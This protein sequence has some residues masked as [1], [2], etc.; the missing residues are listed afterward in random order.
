VEGVNFGGGERRDKEEIEA[1]AYH[2]HH[3][4]I[5]QKYILNFAK[6]LL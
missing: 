1:A 5:E 4:M 2:A 3:K 6:Q